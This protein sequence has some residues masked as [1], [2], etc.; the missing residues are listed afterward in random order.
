MDQEYIDVLRLNPNHRFEQVSTRSEN[1]KG[2]DTDFY[3]YREYDQDG[4]L[5]GT[6]TIADS[7]C[8]YPP[9]KRTIRRL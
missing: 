8:I 3:E 9:Q 2:H 6:F 5:V 7:M 4:N 1:R